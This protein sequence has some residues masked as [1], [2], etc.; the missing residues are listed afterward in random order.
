MNLSPAPSDSGA[1]DIT[2]LLLTGQ[3]PVLRIGTTLDALGPFLL[4]SSSG[5]HPNG[6]PLGG[7][8]ALDGLRLCIGLDE[9]ACLSYWVL[10]RSLQ[11]RSLL[12]H[13]ADRKVLLGEVDAFGLLREL[14]ELR[15]PYVREIWL[16]SVCVITILQSGVSITFDLEPVGTVGF[17]AIQLS[18]QPLYLGG[19]VFRKPNY[20]KG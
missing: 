10:K 5:T 19:D 18:P 11:D 15:L 7:D 3:H 20:D 1:L 4:W 17:G 12:L 14:E 13:A 9:R 2:E 8:V 16:N 6:T